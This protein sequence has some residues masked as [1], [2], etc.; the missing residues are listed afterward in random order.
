MYQRVLMIPEHGV[1]GCVPFL[2]L[3]HLLTD[4]KKVVTC[5]LEMHVTTFFLSV[6][7]SQFTGCGV[8]CD[9]KRS[10]HTGHGYDGLAWS[11]TRKA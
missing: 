1:F 2:T 10:S 8:D 4:K 5:T 6:D 11:K 3:S 7:H 9:E